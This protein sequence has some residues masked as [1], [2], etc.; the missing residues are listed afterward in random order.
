MVNQESEIGNL[1]SVDSDQRTVGS[2]QQ[3]RPCPFCGSEASYSLMDDSDNY[4]FIHCIECD[5]CPAEMNR[6]AFYERDQESVKTE[7]IAKWN[8]RYKTQESG[9]DAR[10]KW[11]SVKDDLPKDRK[12]KVLVR[13]ER[14]NSSEPEFGAGWYVGGLCG[15][16]TAGGF[17]KEVT[18]W[19]RIDLNE[20]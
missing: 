14:Y 11:I 20:E 17:L 13:G 4:G 5:D 7:L 10:I 2:D 19:A 16:E 9:K 15:W 3:L 6:F 1:K 12:E 8:R 18:H